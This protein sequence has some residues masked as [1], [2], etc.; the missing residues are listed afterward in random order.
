MR[1][2]GALGRPPSRGLV[3]CLPDVGGGDQVAPQDGP[4]RP[5]S[6][7]IEIHPS[8]RE[9]DPNIPT[10]ARTTPGKGVS[11]DTGVQFG[12]PAPKN[13][14]RELGDPNPGDL[15]PEESTPYPDDGW[16]THQPRAGT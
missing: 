4:G 5:P 13:T 10:I 12:D 3:G 15:G 16:G 8:L 2:G 14:D 9:S 1:I 7:T 11:G 6:P